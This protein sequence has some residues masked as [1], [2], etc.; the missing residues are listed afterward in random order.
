MPK[1]I[2]NLEHRLIEEAKKQIE[3]AGYG[4][5]TIRSVAKA[6]GVGVG[7]VYNDF[8]SK[9]ALIATHLLEDWKQCVT[10]IGTALSVLAAVTGLPSLLLGSLFAG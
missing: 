9:E 8:S 7:T 4:A 1:R 3:K 10:A 5:M 6:C 2:E